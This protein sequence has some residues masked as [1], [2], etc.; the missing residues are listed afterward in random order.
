M[1]G[2]HE[3]A[4]IDLDRLVALAEAVQTETWRD[5]N[6]ALYVGGPDT[7]HGRPWAGTVFVGGDRQ[8]LVC[9]TWAPEAEQ[10][11]NLA[12]FIAAANPKTVLALVAE[13][14]VMADDLGTSAR[15]I[16]SLQSKLKEAEAKALKMSPVCDEITRI[17]EVYDEQ[18]EKSGYVD[19]PG[20]LENMGDVWRLLKDW[21]GYLVKDTPHA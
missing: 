10:T 1:S 16:T 3:E 20:G 11:A 7:A 4:G 14:T 8:C 15:E 13:I 18:M 12:R 5:G 17:M 9:M 21:R 6:E 2:Q 19:T